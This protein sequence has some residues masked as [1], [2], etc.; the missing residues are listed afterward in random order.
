MIPPSFDD[1][2]RA[3]LHDLFVWRRDVRHFRTDPLPEDMVERLLSVA[4]LAPSV[5]L[6]EPWRLVRVGSVQARQA[7]RDAFTR[8]NQDALSAREGDDATRYARLKLAGLDR[9]PLQLAVF[10]EPDPA[11]GRGLGR[12]TMPE[13]TSFSAVLAIH[14]LWLTARAEGIGLGWVSILDP[15]RMN[16]ILD[17]PPQWRFIA[18][19]CLGFPDADHSIPEL[20]RQGWEQRDPDP[21]ILER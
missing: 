15:A 2:F 7:V 14:T 18:I 1:A 10:A 16:A 3:R 8:C 9:A 13:T 20:A 12:R 6:S 4:R 17:V 5:G 21:S 19:L 11:R